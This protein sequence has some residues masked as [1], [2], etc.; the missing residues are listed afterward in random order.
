[1]HIFSKNQELTRANQFDLSAMI[2]VLHS[3]S[4]LKSKLNSKLINVLF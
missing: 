3:K 4:K 2:I 1:M